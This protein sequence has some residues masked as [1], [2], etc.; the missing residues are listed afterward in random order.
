[1][2]VGTDLTAMSLENKLV[3]SGIVDGGFHEFESPTLGDVVNFRRVGPDPIW[4]ESR[5][6]VISLYLNEIRL[7]ETVNLL[8]E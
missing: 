6:I 7:Y 3:A 1:M 5:Q 4:Q 8:K 2:R